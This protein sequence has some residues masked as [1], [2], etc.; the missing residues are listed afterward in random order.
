MPLHDFSGNIIALISSRG[1]LLETRDIDAFGEILLTQPSL[2]PWGFSS[3][4]TEEGL[5][6]F[7]GRFY[8]PSLGRWLTPDPAGAIDSPNL[9]LYVRN[10]PL[11]RLDLFGLTSQ[12]IRIEIKKEIWSRKD[13]DFVPAVATFG[14]HSVDCFVRAS[15]I[16]KIQFS[17]EEIKGETLSIIDHIPEIIGSNGNIQIV[18]YFNGIKNTEADHLAGLKSISNN[19]EKVAPGNDCVMIGMFKETKG[20]IGDLYDVIKQKVGIKTSEVILGREI[21]T[22]FAEII[23][24]IH[25]LNT[26][27]SVA[28]SGGGS[29]L[30]GAFNCMNTDQKERMRN[31]IL[32]VNIAPASCISNEAALRATN[33]YSKNDLITGIFGVSSTP[34]CRAT[35]GL[36]GAMCFRSTY[37]VTFLESNRPISQGIDHSILYN[38]Q[39]KALKREFKEL[40][41]NY[42]FYKKAR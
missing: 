37:N 5:V 32:S 27:A 28:H 15:Q 6:Y 11:S 17:P 30:R 33:S 12:P 41:E 31:R 42:G 8:D 40:E 4:R 10:N 1:S 35:G 9:Y 13:L 29:W 3:K 25:P 36:V 22:T 38:T 18:L 7:V 20:A 26:L 34:A 16:E 21:L 39:Q 23:E 14:E 2:S 19:L 24:R